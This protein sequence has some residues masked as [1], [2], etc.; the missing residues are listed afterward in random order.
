MFRIK[1]SIFQYN[2]ILWPMMNQMG[3]VKKSILFSVLSILSLGVSAQTK[4][5]SDTIPSLNLDQCIAYGLQNQ[6]GVQQSDIGITIAKKTNMIALSGCLPQLNDD[7]NLYHYSELPTAHQ[8]NQANPNEAPIPT[9]TG[10]Y[11]TLT[12]QLTATENIF[13]PGL[14]YAAK[15]AHL[16][17]Q[18]A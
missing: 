6:P 4:N 2:S 11:N 3:R 1:Q 12:P 17:V 7:A 14:L 15:S 8:T 16:Y 13:S 5:P 9:K 10:V 18:Q